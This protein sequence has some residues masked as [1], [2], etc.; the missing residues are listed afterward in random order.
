[1]V[2]LRSVVV[3]DFDVRRANL[4]AGPFKANPAL[5]I[6]ADAV[7]AFAVAFKSFERARSRPIR[8]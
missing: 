5:H 2:I 3:H 8:G 7:L 4:P 1:M 6:D